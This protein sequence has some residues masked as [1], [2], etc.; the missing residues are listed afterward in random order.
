MDTEKRWR[1]LWHALTKTGKQRRK[2]CRTL[3][4]ELEKLYSQPHRHYHTLTHIEGCLAE[5]DA[6]EPEAPTLLKLAL[7]YHDAIYDT[8]AHDNE[9]RSAAL[10]LSSM[11]NFLPGEDL[12]RMEVLIMATKHNDIP[13]DADCRLIIDCDLAILGKPAPVYQAYREAVRKEYA[14]ADETSFRNGRMTV[15][16]SFLNRPS[17]Y[18]THFFREHYEEQARCNLEFEMAHLENAPDLDA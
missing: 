1:E 3:R 15:L 5:C 17:I 6:A 4:E 2:K 13:T 16:K 10:A 8:K 18:Q 11:R 9:E 7:C 12:K 14:W